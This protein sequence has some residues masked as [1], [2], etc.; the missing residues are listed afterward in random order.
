LWRKL[1]RDLQPI[2]LINRQGRES[3]LQE[4][5]GSKGFMADDGDDVSRAAQ[6][7][8]GTLFLLNGRLLEK[9][10]CNDDNVGAKSIGSRHTFKTRHGMSRSGTV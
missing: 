7:G 1:D 4:R 6:T 9:K 5:N 8:T 10:P 3:A 2:D